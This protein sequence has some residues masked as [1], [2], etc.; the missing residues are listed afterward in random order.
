M[1]EERRKGYIVGKRKGTVKFLAGSG[2][3]ESEKRQILYQMTKAF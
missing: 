2:R 3:D 1:K